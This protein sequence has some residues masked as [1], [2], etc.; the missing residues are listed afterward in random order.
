MFGSYRFLLAMLVVVSH[1]AA[2]PAAAHYGAYAVRGFFILSG[3][4]ITAALHD[5]YRFDLP[6]F[7]A[8]R[9]LRLMPCYLATCLATLALILFLPDAGHAFMSR[10][11]GHP[12]L[13]A[14]GQNV[15][16]LPLAFDGLQLRLF[17]PGWSLAVE[18]MMYALL[19]V[20]MVRNIGLACCG[21]VFGISYHAT[22][23]AIGAHFNLRYFAPPASILCFSIGALTYFLHIEYRATWQL[24]WRPALA[25][26]VAAAWTANLVLAPAIAG[27]RH[28]LLGSFYVNV[29]CCGLLVL[30]LADVKATGFAKTADQVLGQLAYPVFLLQWIAGFIAHEL[31]TPGP[32]R[33]WDLLIAAC[34]VLL[35]LSSVMAIA[36]IK[37]IDPL[38][39]TI[40]SQ[41]RTAVPETLITAAAGAPRDQMHRLKPA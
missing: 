10:W 17:E 18:L 36:Q 30:L 32:M 20:G 13:T 22:M 2:A 8:N 31:I 21:L 29:L 35:V 40:R 39:H 23:V 1:L 34:P 3:F 27:G 25:C 9:L 14:I 11:H 33:G 24:R 28:V 38:R 19:S 7:W 15:I 6:R 41:V 37:L 16:L 26:I 4:V 12:T 5:T